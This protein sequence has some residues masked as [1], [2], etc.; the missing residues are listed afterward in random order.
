[1]SVLN[2]YDQLL[3]LIRKVQGLID[4]IDDGYPLKGWFAIE[5]RQFTPGPRRPTMEDLNARMRAV[6]QLEHMVTN[7]PQNQPDSQSSEESTYT[8]M[9]R[10]PALLME[11][12]RE[13]NFSIEPALLLEGKQPVALF[14]LVS[15]TAKVVSYLR[16]LDPSLAFAGMLTC[17][18]E[19][20]AILQDL[21]LVDPVVQEKLSLLFRARYH[22]MNAAVAGR[23]VHQVLEIAAGISPRGLHWSREHP[24]TVYVESDL[25]V[26]MREKAKALRNAIQSDPVPRRGV[27][28]CCGLDALDLAGLHHALDYTDPAAALV[29]V[30][31]GL[32]LYFTLE[33]V[34]RFLKNMHAVLAE[35]R[36]AVWVVDLVSQQNLVDLFAADPEAAAAVKRVF[37]STQ[38]EVVTANPFPDEAAIEDALQ[39]N[40]LR[41]ASRA[42]L[43][44]SAVQGGHFPAD[45]V[46]Q[47]RTLCGSRKIWT[48][49]AG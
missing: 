44:E 15:P 48:V 40:G 22:C 11:T 43:S 18:E 33:E 6:R 31:E 47:V 34:T 39:A 19:S 9:A 5:L 16:N 10:V 26:L 49:T 45:L 20:R 3:K 27:L 42:L 13:T 2:L 12:V 32:L 8:S 4:G 14:D 1:M 37:A 25:P 41:V 21:G 28:H 24:G 23:E 17:P 36:D 38:R 29:I 30:T 7:L 46:P 35:R